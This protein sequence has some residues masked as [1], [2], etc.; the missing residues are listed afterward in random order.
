MSD[1]TIVEVDYWE[2]QTY[3]Q[4]Q[5]G[6]SVPYY[7][8]NKFSDETGKI[9][10]KQEKTMTGTVFLP[11]GWEWVDKSWEIDT[12]GKYGE[13]D[14]EGWSYATSFDILVEQT[15]LHDLRS[16]KNSSSMMRRRRWIR[17]RRC[18][19]PDVVKLHVERVEWIDS[20]RH[21]I[22][23]VQAMDASNKIKLNE[24]SINQK[25]AIEKVIVA[26]D[27]NIL[28]VIHEFD[29]K[30]EKLQALKT[31]IAERG[32]IEESYAQK[33]DL[34]SKKWINEGDVRRPPPGP[35]VAVPSPFLISADP[36]VD[37]FAEEGTAAAFWNSTT[38][39]FKTAATATTQAANSAATAAATAAN[40]AV[41][42]AQANVRR[43]SYTETDLSGIV[44]ER[45]R[46]DTGKTDNSTSEMSRNG[47][48]SDAPQLAANASTAA[49][50]PT[51]S[52][53]QGDAHNPPRGILDDYYYSVCLANRTVGQRLQ[54]YSNS[55]T[56]A[57]PEQVDGI[58]EVVKDAVSECRGEGR[59]IR[60][61]LMNNCKITEQKFATYLQCFE[62]SQTE[63]KAESNL[64]YAS[65][66]QS[67]ATMDFP[68]SESANALFSNTTGV[69]GDATSIGDSAAAATN[70]FT[71]L[72]N[73]DV[74]LAIQ[75]YFASA[76]TVDSVLL[77]YHAFSKM[78][79][80]KLREISLTIDELLHVTLKAFSTEQFRAWEDCSSALAAL[81]TYKDVLVMQVRGLSSA[82]RDGQEGSR[83]PRREVETSDFKEVNSSKVE[84]HSP[85][86]SPVRGGGC[87]NDNEIDDTMDDIGLSDQTMADAYVNAGR[88]TASG[89]RA[90]FFSAMPTNKYVAHH[91]RLNYYTTTRAEAH[92]GG[93]DFAEH[94]IW[95]EAT[96]VVTYDRVMHLLQVPHDGVGTDELKYQNGLIMSIN[97]RNVL[98]RPFAIP[99]EGYRD[100]FEVLLAGS[101]SKKL[102]MLGSLSSNS[103]G[104]TA[105]IFLTQDSFL[106]RSWMRA[107]SHPFVDTTKDP[108][109]SPA[110]TPIANS[111]ASSLPTTSTTFTAAS[112]TGTGTDNAAV[113]RTFSDGFNY[114]GSDDIVSGSNSLRDLAKLSGGSTK[115]APS[116]PVAD[117]T[118][119]P[120]LSL[121]ENF[122]G[123][124]LMRK[125][126]MMGSATKTAA[127]TTGA[128][129]SADSEES[130]AG[131]N[132]MR[133]PKTTTA[134]T[135]SSS[136]APVTSAASTS[137]STTSASVSA[138][139][140]GVDSSLPG[141]GSGSSGG[142]SILTS[143]NFSGTNALRRLKRTPSSA[144][145]GMTAA[146]AA[147][148]EGNNNS[149]DGDSS[150]KK[151]DSV[152]L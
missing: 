131:T 14:S 36:A 148:T 11:L 47:S 59:T 69:Y 150:P 15:R 135:S 21:K 65:V 32:A 12:S 127:P 149:S 139:A 70:R 130:I 83:S 112:P 27:N 98:V 17:N 60:T 45:S 24:Y 18:V 140:N 133:A 143:E 88:D 147:S 38:N 41:T 66:R 84:K 99:K 13:C 26:T 104:I 25:E 30:I 113:A 134:S 89:F 57:L 33:M 146:H 53:S 3:K 44:E 55:L 73:V 64:M 48:V 61:D 108:P 54:T 74:W 100:A 72:E 96:V 16:D 93:I 117:T 10:F 29:D 63:K 22:Q 56:Q 101:S 4:L 94:S 144:G 95:T 62:Q 151:D 23:E 9:A 46:S 137:V 79:L 68:V 77:M 35:G 138:P 42:A 90:S 129:S 145:P 87:A 78:Q 91:G 103:K 118:A 80:R 58:L 115:T 31:F 20:I 81:G 123:T 28:E 8:V 92:A 2:N 114:G 97:M 86:G 76:T 71:G 128:E 120:A 105:I 122:T 7:G 50:P 6:W 37:I 141:G 19:I 119:A 39:A 109:D 85:A 107:I 67:S 110:P 132:M 82:S 116:T 106:M 1:N 102:G 152:S 136:S 111:A 5:G 43:M 124:N 75:Q 126:P 51:P 125:M 34:F 40:A 142:S 121:G 52:Q 49:N